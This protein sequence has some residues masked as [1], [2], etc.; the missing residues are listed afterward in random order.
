MGG[1]SSSR[2]ESTQVTTTT[3]QQ[4]GITGDEN[5]QVS[6][7]ANLTT[8]NNTTNTTSSVDESQNLDGTFAVGQG[9]NSSSVINM[10][11]PGALS[12]AQEALTSTVDFGET[13]VA[14]Q[15]RQAALI[16][17]GIADQTRAASKSVTEAAT[18]ASGNKVSDI[19]KWIPLAAILAAGVV[20]YAFL[21]RKRG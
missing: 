2:Q 1:R 17:G 6:Q 3:T 9:S 18:I 16:A 13:L 15:E 7:G 10:V 5:I 8:N 21:T 14:S 12:F 20:A 19:G 4:A 11:D